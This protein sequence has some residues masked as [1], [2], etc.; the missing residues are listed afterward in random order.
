MNQNVRRARKT[1]DKASIK[2]IEILFSKPVPQNFEKRNKV[3]AKREKLKLE[4]FIAHRTKV[5]EN[6]DIAAHCIPIWGWQRF[7]DVMR[8]LIRPTLIMMRG[9]YRKG[10]VTWFVNSYVPV[11]GV[12]CHLK[13]TL[14]VSFFH[15]VKTSKFPWDLVH[16]KKEIRFSPLSSRRMNVMCMLKNFGKCLC[17]WRWPCPHSFSKWPAFR[18]MH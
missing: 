12:I 2:G 9:F 10:K 5:I 7:L 16:K 11:W 4:R 8:D 1:A 15:F 17:R 14:S 6:G 18:Y 13:L 3:F